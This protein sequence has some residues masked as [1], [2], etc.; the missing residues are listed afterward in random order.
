MGNAVPQDK[1]KA[2]NETVLINLLKDLSSLCI[3]QKY[4]TGEVKK[5][6][7]NLESDVPQMHTLKL[8]APL[9][10]NLHTQLSNPSRHA[11]TATVQIISDVTFLY[12]YLFKS[13][14]SWLNV[15]GYPWSMN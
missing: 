1:N 6:Y 4:Y 10:L 5:D 7:E 8:Y 14:R 9:H 12:I 15:C 2:V 3:W 13:P 11:Q